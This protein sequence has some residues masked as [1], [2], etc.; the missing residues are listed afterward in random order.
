AVAIDRRKVNWVVDCDIRAFF[1][2]VS[3][4]WL[5]R[6]LEH[7]IGDRRVIRLI[8][9]WLKAGVMVDGRWQDT[10]QGT[11]QGSVASPM[12]SEPYDSGNLS[13]SGR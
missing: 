11:P 10:A 12:L 6:F 4:D 3:R 8:A 7:R 5:V 13:R 2:T 9:K 1:D